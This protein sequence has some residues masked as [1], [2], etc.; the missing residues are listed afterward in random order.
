MASLPSVYVVP[1]ETLPWYAGLRDE[2]VQVHPQLTRQFGGP[3]GLGQHA[4][5]SSLPLK[6]LSLR[7][8]E[9][10]QDSLDYVLTR[11]L[12]HYSGRVKDPSS[13]NV[14]F[15]PTSALPLRFLFSKS[16]TPECLHPPRGI[17]A[18]PGVK[19][20][21]SGRKI[22]SIVERNLMLEMLS[23]K[24]IL[25]SRSPIVVTLAKLPIQHHGG[26]YRPWG[27]QLDKRLHFLGTDNIDGRAKR[28]SVLP[29]TVRF[30]FDSEKAMQ[31]HVD[32]SVN[33]SSRKYFVHLGSPRVNTNS[34]SFKYRFMFI[35]TRLMAELSSS[36]SCS[37]L[38][39]R[40]FSLE[41]NYERMLNSIF[42]LQPPGDSPTRRGFF[43]SIMLGCIPVVLSKN[44]YTLVQDRVEDVAVVVEWK[45][46]EN[47]GG[48]LP[49]LRSLSKQRITELQENVMRAGPR[50]QYSSFADERSDAFHS[51]LQVMASFV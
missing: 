30:A 1:R 36:S 35:R 46:V 21:M 22:V 40:S 3:F 13:A 49:I 4:A 12:E 50:M 29:W 34:T 18:P 17:A 31:A 32:H 45:R 44:A 7:E 48:I 19:R 43:D 37:A 23:R 2:C 25:E 11:K 47:A 15:I 20:K 10:P 6:Q 8:R 33:P 27:S 24:E 39:H 28:V 9:T 41:L 14:L 51:A 42:C 5:N 16:L 26:L 38:Q